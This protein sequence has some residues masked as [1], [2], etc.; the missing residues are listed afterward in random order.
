MTD[1]EQKEFDPADLC[2]EVPIP[3]EIVKHISKQIAK[4]KSSA[5]NYADRTSNKVPHYTPTYLSWC[6]R[7]QYY[8]LMQFEKELLE[9]DDEF[10][11]GFSMFRGTALHNAFSRIYRWSE[12]P[13]K[14]QFPISEAKTVTISGRLDM[15]QPYDAE[16]LDLKTTKFLGWQKKSSFVPRTKDVRQVQIYEVLYSK[17]LPVKKLTLIYADMAEL[18][19]FNVPFMPVEIRY[20]LKN[21]ITDIENSIETKTPPPGEVTKLCDYC[22]FQTRCHGDKG[23]IITKPKSHPEVNPQ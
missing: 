4:I 12:L 1:G 2:T 14:L 9:A 21:R 20:W 15:Y 11:S 7:L 22:P 13:L 19:A 10:S 8:I 16:I 6:S 3:A 18:V 5:S 17:I 23:G